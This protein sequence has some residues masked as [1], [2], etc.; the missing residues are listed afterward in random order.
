[1]LH[2]LVRVLLDQAVNPNL[3][4]KDVIRFAAF[5]KR[6]LLTCGIGKP[7]NADTTMLD[8]ACQSLLKGS[9]EGVLPLVTAAQARV[10]GDNRT[11][12]AMYA[13]FL[14][15][16]HKLPKAPTT[17]SAKVKNMFVRA[18]TPDSLHSSSTTPTTFDLPKVPFHIEV[19]AWINALSKPF[20][21]MHRELSSQREVGQWISEFNPETYQPTTMN[22]E[23]ERDVKSYMSIRLFAITI[24]LMGPHQDY[25]TRNDRF[26]K[27]LNGLQ[28][29]L[30]LFSPKHMAMAI[31]ELMA[32]AKRVWAQVL[33]KC[34]EMLGLSFEPAQSV[35]SVNESLAIVSYPDLGDAATVEIQVL[36]AISSNQLFQVGF[37]LWRAV[38]LLTV[39][40]PGHLEL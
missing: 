35:K 19:L 30:K 34:I 22:D 4:G 14:I 20:K 40:C 16:D 10:Q 8:K 28:K 15:L 6:H 5:F 39:L 25:P 29:K 36:E 32:Q 17:K 38:P 9:V 11:A 33:E 18:F 37:A 24:R 31:R 2:V 12:E 3:L 13:A 26:G 23:T 7:K 1:M 21:P 27:R